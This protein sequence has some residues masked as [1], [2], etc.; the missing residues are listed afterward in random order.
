MEASMPRCLLS[1]VSCL[2]LLLEKSF[3]KLF[4]TKSFSVL[5]IIRRPSG[6]LM[7]RFVVGQGT[8]INVVLFFKEGYLLSLFD[9]EVQ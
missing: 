1:E 3:H 2:V 5:S 4:K 9:L 6:P 7:P 8:S